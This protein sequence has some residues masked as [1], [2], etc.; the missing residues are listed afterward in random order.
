MNKLL[1]FAPRWRRAAGCAFALML[2]GLPGLAAEPKAEAPARSIAATG[3]I[4]RREARDKDWQIVTKGESLPVGQLLLGLPEA[5]IESANGAVRLTMDSDMSG[6]SPYPVMENAIILRSNPDWDLDFTLDRGRITITNTKKEGP[7]N[8]RV[9]I[10][11]HVGDL[12]LNE[13]GSQITLELYGRWP[14]GVPFTPK[15]GPK[16]VPT[17]DL[18]VLCTHGEVSVSTQGQGHLLTAPPGPA[19]IEWDNVT[20]IDPTPHR[21]EKLPPWAQPG[22]RETDLYRKKMAGL[23]RF[24]KRAVET[25]DV[26][27]V[28]HQYVT[29]DDPLERRLAVFGM[30]AIDDLRG[31]SQALQDTKHQDVWDN[32]ILALRHWIG[33]APGQDQYL[34][35]A[36]MEKVNFSPVEAES[37][38]QLLH[39]FGDEDLARPETYEMLIDYLGHDKFPIRGLAYWHLSRLVPAGKEFGYNPSESKEARQAAITKWRQLIPRGKMPPKKAE[40]K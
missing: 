23:A 10:L 4:L 36:L 1:T 17:A 21:L 34:Y 15:P 40:G 39:S 14:R 24:V 22:A 35:H 8:V 38:L 32:G 26:P 28:L 20:G 31:L 5:G 7:A 37:V 16:D 12:T 18:I 33:R 27:A 6:L 3:W 29:S 13:P 25:R 11:D 30:G 9:H 2:T 19:M